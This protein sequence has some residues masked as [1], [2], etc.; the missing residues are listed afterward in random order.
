MIAV[1]FIAFFILI[2]IGFCYGI[3]RIQT[4]RYIESQRISQED[5]DRA[6][7]QAEIDR[8]WQERGKVI[9]PRYC[10]EMDEREPL[11]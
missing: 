2:G 9:R 5:L 8:I 10:S 11:T 3:Y 7:K 6:H 4:D 1:I